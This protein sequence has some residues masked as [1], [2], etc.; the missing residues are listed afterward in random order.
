MTKSE[1][2]VTESRIT[3]VYWNY[4]DAAAGKDQAN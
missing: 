3:K 2:H 1:Q 4:F